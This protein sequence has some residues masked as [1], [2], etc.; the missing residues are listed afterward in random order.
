MRVGDLVE[1]KRAAGWL[2]GKLAILLKEKHEGCWEIKIFG[3]T[4]SMK[5]PCILLDEKRFEVVSK[6]I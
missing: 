1:I 2:N 6:K 4:F 5:S 3:P